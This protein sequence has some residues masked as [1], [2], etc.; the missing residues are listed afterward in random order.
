L[1]RILRVSFTAQPDAPA[2]VLAGASGWAVND[3]INSLFTPVTPTVS[4]AQ[5]RFASRQP[6]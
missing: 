6:R 1:S 2:F 5:Q 3:E 4:A